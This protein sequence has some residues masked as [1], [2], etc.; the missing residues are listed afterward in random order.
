MSIQNFY[1]LI[2][3][4]NEKD[5]VDLLSLEKVCWAP[6]LRTDRETIIKRIQTFPIG[7]YV[8]ELDGKICGVL[9]TRRI[10]DE[11]L[12]TENGSYE[13]HLLAHETRGKILHFLS[14]SVN[15]GIKIGNIA[16]SLRSSQ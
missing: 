1:P 8:I 9:Y 11:K 6:D 13:K 16:S 2:R 14:I 10:V 5:V 15:P 4:A 3:N 12:L 7:Q